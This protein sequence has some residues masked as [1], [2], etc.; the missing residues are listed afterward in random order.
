MVGV[1]P[2][3][4]DCPALGRRLATHFGVAAR[5]LRRSVVILLLSVLA[6]A[7][8]VAQSAAVAAPA[9]EPI[10][11]LPIQMK[12]NG[13]VSGSRLPARLW[14]RTCATDT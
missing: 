11:P 10:L 8:S 3:L 14:A 13:R 5:Y 4:V 1:S 12:K 2:N 6:S 7:R 9:S